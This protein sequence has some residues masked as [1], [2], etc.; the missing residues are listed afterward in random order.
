[1]NLKKI[2]KISLI[3]IIILIIIDQSSKILIKK[4]VSEDI[5]II[6]NFL[7]ITKVENEGIAFGLNKNNIANICLTAIVLIV[8]INYIINQKAN[9][10]TKIIVFLSMILAGG[11]SN[12]ID[13]IFKGGVFD[14]IEI[15]N[16]PVFNFADIL[17]VVGW[18]LFAV[19]FILYSVKE[20]KIEK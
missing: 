20:V 12:L 10:T 5:S 4:F 6:T 17:I 9:M 16:F 2:L 15:I 1:M 7:T 14:F 3:I 8:I 11:F 18:I 13:R 19:N